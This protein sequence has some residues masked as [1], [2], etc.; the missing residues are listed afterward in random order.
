MESD[1]NFTTCEMSCL[2]DRAAASVFLSAFLPMVMK[3]CRAATG[4][5]QWDRDGH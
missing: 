5:S 1:A 2:T 4:S 3:L